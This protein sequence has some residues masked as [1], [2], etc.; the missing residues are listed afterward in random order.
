MQEQ[1]TS[2]PAAR[3]VY[4]VHNQATT[5]SWDL[6]APKGKQLQGLRID[7][8]AN[9]TT[10]ATG[11]GRFHKIIKEIKVVGD[12]G[13]VM[14]VIQDSVPITAVASQAM[15]EDRFYSV[16]PGTTDVVRNPIVAAA[17]TDYDATYNFHT[18]LPGK[19]FNVRVDLESALVAWPGAT[20]M[21]ALT[22][23][24][25]VTAIWMASIGQPQYMILGDRVSN[26]TEKKYQNASKVALFNAN[27]WA[28]VLSAVKLGETLSNAQVGINEDLANDKLRGLAADGTGTA[29]RTLPILDP[30]TGADVYA[31]IN[32]MDKPGD[33]D[34][35][36]NASQTLSAIV[37]TQAGRVEDANVTN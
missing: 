12:N 4:N 31:L 22:F 19:K 25:V 11:T 37:F 16:T 6:V 9:A 29:T 7:A 5:L 34:I 21:T 27:E 14:D 18:P 10:L 23:D 3:Q 28:S 26:I 24:M 36:A 35:K 17:A 8:R 15:K 13:S 2:I 33:I 20:A 30:A 32:T 1:V